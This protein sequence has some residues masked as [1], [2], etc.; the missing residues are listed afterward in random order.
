MKMIFRV[1]T[2]RAIIR[3]ECTCIIY[4]LIQ[5]KEVEDFYIATNNEND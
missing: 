5:P 2:F 4:N 3:K 1:R